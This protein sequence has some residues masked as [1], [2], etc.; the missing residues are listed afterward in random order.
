MRLLILIISTFLTIGTFSSAKEVKLNLMGSLF[1]HNNNRVKWEFYYSFPDTLLKYV[2][3]GDKYVGEMYFKIQFHSSIKKE[4][5]ETW[6]VTHSSDSTIDEF[7]LNLVGQK[8]FF[9]P[10]GQYNA[11][12]K[13]T[14]KHDSSTSDQ[15]EFKIL[16]RKFAENKI[17]IS[18]IE[19]ANII[20][21]AGKN[22]PKDMFYKNTLRVVPNPNLEFYGKDPFCKAYLEI[23]NAQKYAP[24]GFTLKYKIL[25]SSEKEMFTVPRKKKSAANGIVDYVEIPIELLPTGAYYLKALIQY[26]HKGKTDSAL[27]RQKFYFINPDMS[28]REHTQFVESSSFEQSVFSTMS[29][30]RVRIEYEKAKYIAAA[31]EK[32]KYEMLSTVEAKQR[33]LYRFWQNRDPKEETPVNEKYVEY[34]NLADYADTYFSSGIKQAGWRTDRGRVLLKYGMPTQRDKNPSKDYNRAYEV[35][36]YDELQGGV[37]FYFVD[38]YSSSDYI[39]VHSTLMGEIYNP[40]WYDQYVPIVRDNNQ[41]DRNNNFNNQ[42]YR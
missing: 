8:T 7:K 40:D 38:I 12:V 16:A 42:L 10:I 31:K 23:Y 29:A 32:D 5:E 2:K 35:W 26:E 24:E 28:P 15:T 17:S 21:K 37:R 34:Q 33:F 27:S 18:D 4:Y 19:L 11:Q 6:I 3:K 36:Y 14:D 1:R 39:L 25:N 13:V 41:D 22:A 20:E 30:E 9:L